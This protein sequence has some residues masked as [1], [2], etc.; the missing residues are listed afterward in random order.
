MW[1]ERFIFAGKIYP[2]NWIGSVFWSWQNLL[3]IH[4]SARVECVLGASSGV[5]HTL[6]PDIYYF[7]LAALH[8]FSL[9]LCSQFIVQFLGLWWCN[10]VEQIRQVFWLKMNRKQTSST[11]TNT[12]SNLAPH[13]DIFRSVTIVINFATNLERIKFGWRNSMRVNN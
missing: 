6:H 5:T 10:A 9:L 4:C 11:R 12:A 1:W 8:F 13:T 3:F 2:P 7:A